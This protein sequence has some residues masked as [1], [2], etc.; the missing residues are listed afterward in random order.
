[1]PDPILIHER[2]L[3]LRSAKAVA[4]ELGCPRSAVSIG[5]LRWR[6]RTCAVGGPGRPK[7][8]GNAAPQSG[9]AVERAVAI[10]R[11]EPGIALVDVARLAGTSPANVSQAKRRW[12]AGKQ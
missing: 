7:G 11:R 10:M 9:S 2:F 6:L 1:M 4:A 5:L 12:I 3:V 8:S